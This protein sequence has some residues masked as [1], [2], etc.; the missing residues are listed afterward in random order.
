[1]S[2]K[3]LPF[4]QLLYQ[5]LRRA[6]NRLALDCW[7]D[8]VPLVVKRTV[9]RNGEFPLAQAKK[10]PLKKVEVP[11]TWKA[12]GFSTTWFNVSLPKGFKL[13]PGDHIH[14][15]DNAEATVYAGGQPVFGIDC[16]HRQW[17]WPKGQK[18][19]WVE[20][21]FCQSGIWH[22]L[23]KGIGP[24]GS[25]LA[26]ARIVRKDEV[27][28]KAYFDLEVLADWLE[29][30][31]RRA[32][33]QE[34]VDKLTMGSRPWPE[35]DSASGAMSSPD[36]VGTGIPNRY[37]P[38][39]KKLPPLLRCVFKELTE[40]VVVYYES[41]AAALSKRL[42]KTYQLLREHGDVAP[43]ATLI[44]NS[45]LDLVWLWPESVGEKKAVRNCS[46]VLN[47]LENNPDFTFCYSQPASYE[48]IARRQPKLFGRIE[49]QI[50]RGAWE[51]TGAMYVE[52]DILVGAGEALLRSFTVGQ[53]EFEKLRGTPSKVLW[54]PD[55]FGYPGCMPGLMKLAGVEGFFT[56][57]ISW[58]MIHEFPHTSFV[59]RGN[60]GVEVLGYVN[61]HTVYNNPARPR[62]L[63]IEAEYDRQIDT[64]KEILIPTGWGDGAGGPTIDI[65]ERVRRQKNLRN[66]PAARFGLIEDFYDRMEKVREQLPIHQGE[67]PLAAHRG[68][69]STHGIVKS[70]YR[71]S[72]KGLRAWE[73]AH[74]LAG[75]GAIDRHAWKRLIFSQFHDCLPGASI[76]DAYDEIIPEMLSTAAKG[77]TGA[78]KALDKR[79]K[80]QTLFNPLPLPLPTV[81]KNKL[82][83]L[84]PLSISDPKKL[85]ALKCEPLK[86]SA[87][88]LGNE[89]VDARFDARG[90]FISLTVDNKPVFTRAPRPVV[91]ND[92][93]YDH[94][95]WEIDRDALYNGQPLQLLGL[96]KPESGE[97][98]VG[99]RQKWRTAKGSTVDILW[100][101]RQGANV[102]EAQV[103]MDWK[104]HEKLLRFEVPS[105]YRG[106]SALFAAPFGGQWRPQTSGDS[107]AASLW[108]APANRWV[109]AS[110]DGRREGAFIVAE[111]KYGFT[112]HDGLLSVTLL[113]SAKITVTNAFPASFNLRKQEPKWSDLG[114]QTVQMALGRL[115]ENS[116]RAEHP[117]ALAETLF[118]QPLRV[119][120]PEMALPVAIE[121]L[122][123]LVPVWTVPLG[124]DHFVLRLHET[125][126]REGTIRLP[127]TRG[128][129]VRRIDRAFPQQHAGKTVRGEIAVG[130]FEIVSLEFSKN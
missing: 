122:P 3:I 103:D 64:F 16:T 124:K 95:A 23:A 78:R 98:W 93:P 46:S 101:V 10:C 44:G 31:L 88:H 4:P 62:N 12:D 107:R 85:P 96:G 53:A 92:V 26:N 65:I 73:A 58:D 102:I 25:L 9:S 48:A 49:R 111:S 77:Q 86:I 116:P 32:L 126:G 19:L 69:Y 80:T 100:R 60:D 27:S 52:S 99:L 127:Q 57:K 11:C 21:I 20:S 121:G 110:N 120:A 129:K 72:E 83:V 8:P 89:R 51:A 55:C 117:G 17:P 66:Q 128:W 1:M 39:L 105:A 59:W 33:P 42:E 14:W 24:A 54:L 71:E 18:E 118:A 84:P 90:N 104:E 113:K 56:Q 41:G 13:R 125:I 75:L 34:E 82:V 63:R 106:Q 45:H 50:R 87:R 130:P 70:A 76:L 5:R 67:V 109:L 61:S 30:E 37:R 94:E 114:R 38:E 29:E 74:A 36:G 47:L 112:C 108:E 35:I 22:A 81:Y 91:Y 28:W 43:K 68:T 119:N 2:E 7:R 40:A 123:S 79:A 97:G 15:D 115:D 6:L